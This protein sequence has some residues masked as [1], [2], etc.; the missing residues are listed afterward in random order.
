MAVRRSMFKEP[1]GVLYLKEVYEEKSVLK[2]I[3]IQIDRLLIQNTPAMRLAPYVYDQEARTV[4]KDLINKIGISIHEKDAL[5]NEIKKHLKKNKLK[6]ISGKDYE[7]IKIAEFQEYAAKRVKLDNTFDHKK[8]DKIPYA[9]IG[10][11]ILGDLLHKHLDSLEYEGKPELAFSGEGLE[12]LSRK[13]GKP[14]TKVTIVEKKD[15][16]SKFGK[17]YVEVDAGAVSYFIM[18][19]NK[20]TKEREG[21]A[22]IATHKAIERLNDKTKHGIVDEREG[23]NLIVL[24]PGDLV[25]VPTKEE[26][27]KIKQHI[28]ILEVIPW[29]NHS[30]LS[31]GIYKMIKATDTECHFV[32]YRYINN[33]SI[34]E[35]E[36]GANNCSEKAWDGQITYKENSKGKLTRTDNGTR[37]KD[38]CIKLKI[39]R[40]GNI[41]PINI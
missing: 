7:S 2:V 9:K 31:K 27:E 30:H 22:S 5:L 34:V 1:Q 3:E 40:L 12:S 26:R 8:I 21:F 13:A 4:V 36:F 29:G 18:Y 33:N 24:S 23:Y 38:V 17:Q 10:K 20:L 28:S 37:V 15:F 11:S 39:D 25:Y 19:E 16:N 35:N 6:D 41:T 32:P 14:I